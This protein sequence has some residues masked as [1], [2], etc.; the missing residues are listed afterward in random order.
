MGIDVDDDP[1]LRW[2]RLAYNVSKHSDYRIK[3]GCVLVKGNHPI[4]V[5]FNKLKYSKRWS[6]PWQKSIHAE[7][8]AIRTSGKDRVK[9]ATAYIYREKKNGYPGMARPCDDCMSKLIK[10]G[11]REI[12][13]SIDEFPF[14]R[15]EKI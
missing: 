4:S 8:S 5:G 7:A 15:N 14:W 6:G 3:V 9:N 12:Y 2:F 11:V 10:F 1:H 13:Y